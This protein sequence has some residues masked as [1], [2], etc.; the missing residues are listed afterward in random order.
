LLVLAVVD[1]EDW[2]C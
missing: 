2:V 1:A